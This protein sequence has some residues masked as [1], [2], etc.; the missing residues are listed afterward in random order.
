MK[1]VIFFTCVILS[2]AVNI[3]SQPAL[4]PAISASTVIAPT[5]Y[6][7]GLLQ[8]DKNTKAFPD[9]FLKSVN[10]APAITGNAG[11]NSPA[12]KMGAGALNAATSWTEIPKQIGEVSQEYNPLL[13]VTIGLGEGIMLGLARGASGVA[14]MAT[15]TL[16]P[17]DKPLINPEY[18]VAEPEKGLQLDLVRW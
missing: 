7:M 3:Y 4:D 16:P 14:D 17:Y 1:K 11:A 12:N 6:H 9:A 13:G 2:L 8:P 15:F 5:S 10:T 18:K